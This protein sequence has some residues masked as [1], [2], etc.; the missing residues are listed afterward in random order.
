MNGDY[1]VVDNGSAM[2]NCVTIKFVQLAD[3]VRH[4][5]T[6]DYYVYVKVNYEIPASTISF[7]L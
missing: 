3:I 1:D 6:F 5:I 2:E 4:C 7:V